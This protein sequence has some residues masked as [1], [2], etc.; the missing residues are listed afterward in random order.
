VAFLKKQA[1]SDSSVGEES[2][3]LE[4]TDELEKYRIVGQRDEGVTIR[5]AGGNPESTRSGKGWGKKVAFL[6][7]KTSADS[8]VGEES[9]LLDKVDELEGYRKV[10]KSDEGVTAREAGR[11]PV[12]IRNGKGLVGRGKKW[13]S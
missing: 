1:S 3:L 12:S 13:P 2:G 11:N 4:K 6:R 10:G 5:K 7:K 9:G 8:S